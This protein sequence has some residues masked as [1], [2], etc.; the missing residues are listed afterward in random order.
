[1]VDQIFNLIESLK[2][3]GITILLVEQ[4]AARALKVADR[5]YL[6]NTGTVEFAGDPADMEGE[7]DI[8][9]VYLGGGREL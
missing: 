4:N 7:V 2:G 3:R 1:M 8:T 6:L 5:A 9:S